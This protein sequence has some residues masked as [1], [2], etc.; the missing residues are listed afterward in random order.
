MILPLAQ[1]QADG[2]PRPAAPDGTAARPTPM[3]LRIAHT[4]GETRGS[5]T[6][7]MDPIVRVAATADGFFPA[8]G[9]IRLNL[10]QAIQT[11][12][13]KDVTAVP[14]P[15]VVSP[16]PTVGLQ[17]AQAKTTEWAGRAAA[18]QWAVGSLIDLL[19]VPRVID[20]EASSLFRSEKIQ[21][22][23]MTLMQSLELGESF[24]VEANISRAQ[25]ESQIQIARGAWRQLGPKVDLRMATGRGQYESIS[26]PTPGMSR[27]D[28]SI[29]LRQPL[30]DWGTW[31]EVLRQEQNA[32]AASL[33]RANAQSQAAL[34]AGSGYLSVLQS[35]LIVG[36]TVEY[37]ALLRNLLQ[38]MENRAA[39]GGASPADL[40]RVRARV[41]NARATVSENRA[42][43]VTNLAQF[44][45]ITGSMPSRIE[46][47]PRL[48]ADLPVLAQPAI[49]RGMQ[50]NLDLRAARSLAIASAREADAA[51]GK[52][53]PRFD[54]EVSTTQNRNPSGVVGTQT[55]DRM[56]LI[57]SWNVFSSGVDTAQRAAL[58][59]K[60]REFTL[61]VEGAERRLR[62]QLENAY[63]VLDS[64]EQRFDAVRAEVRANRTVVTAF[65]EQL[66]STNRQLL[67]VLDAYQRFY[68]SKVDLT[69][70]VVTQAQVTLQVAHLL[71]GVRPSD[72]TR[73]R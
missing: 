32:Q 53:M 2:L 46:I 19:D 1:A 8:S 61:R 37:E 52:F 15:G 67:D 68:Q 3:V 29:A 51:R 7:A 65:N 43:L 38:Y 70:L 9:G 44:A 22:G 23:L 59:A 33:A 14:A 12:A 41:E 13:T 56:L 73:L 18:G 50:T 71:G 63:T 21:P 16:A 69:N 10:S 17:L 60:Q 36:Y 49:D 25:E 72:E 47:P 34:D 31:Q 62:Q 40:E 54:L 42:G 5:T 55:D 35:A 27:G 4:L 64:I 24:N 11:V 45:R 28:Q 6:E 57:M 26:G 39:A 58:G 48:R 20:I 66:F 30:F